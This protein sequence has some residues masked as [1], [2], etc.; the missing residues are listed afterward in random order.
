MLNA[1]IGKAIKIYKSNI[2]KKESQNAFLLKNIIGQKKFTINCKMYSF[3]A[4]FF[5]LVSPFEF[6]TRY[7]A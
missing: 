6:K 4:S 5:S 7:E 1:I 3:I 2:T